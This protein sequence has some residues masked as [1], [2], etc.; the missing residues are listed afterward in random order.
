MALACLTKMAKGPIDLADIARLF[1]S[2]VQIALDTSF[3]ALKSYEVHP[4]YREKWVVITE[5]RKIGI[6]VK[7]GHLCGVYIM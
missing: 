2:W 7:L 1:L 6:I 4:F 3:V 5:N